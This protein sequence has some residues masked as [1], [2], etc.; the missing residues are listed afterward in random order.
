MRSIVAAEA[1]ERREVGSDLEAHGHADRAA[2]LRREA[3]PFDDL[4]AASSSQARVWE[5]S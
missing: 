3:G 1:Q 4:L 5:I 2:A